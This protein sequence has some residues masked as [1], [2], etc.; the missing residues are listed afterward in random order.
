M[1]RRG[2][3]A[4]FSEEQVNVLDEAGQAAREGLV[5][6]EQAKLDALLL[7]QDLQALGSRLEQLHAE[8]RALVWRSFGMLA[9]LII[10]AAALVIAAIAIWA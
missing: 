3:E 4:G 1:R 7:R 9:G 5:E 2:R 10:A 8:T 6:E